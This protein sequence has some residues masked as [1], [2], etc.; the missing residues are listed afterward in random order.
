[1]MCRNLRELA[2]LATNLLNTASELEDGNIKAT[3]FSIADE[4]IVVIETMSDEADC[5]D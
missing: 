1:M 2:G 4:I 3:L 5:E